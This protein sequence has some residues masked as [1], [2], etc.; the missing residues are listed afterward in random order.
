MG[1]PG[2]FPPLPPGMRDPRG[3][4]KADEDPAEANRRSVYIVREAQP[5]LSDVRSVRHAR[6]ARELRAP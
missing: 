4:W 3:G 2:V 5:A 6:H 1:G